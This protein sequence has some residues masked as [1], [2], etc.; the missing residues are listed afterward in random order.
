MRSQVLT[1]LLV[2]TLLRFAGLICGLFYGPFFYAVLTLGGL[3]LT[4]DCVTAYL[5]YADDEEVDDGGYSVSFCHR[6]LSAVDRD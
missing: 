4:L 6:I 1:L 5:V 2:I 3:Y